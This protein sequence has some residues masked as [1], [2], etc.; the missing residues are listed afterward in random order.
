[1]KDKRLIR[2]RKYIRLGVRIKI[3]FQ[4]RK[5]KGGQPASDRIRAI[6]RD[7]SMDGISFVSGS[8]LQP[9]DLLKLEIF[10]PSHPKALHLEGKVIWTSPVK[11]MGR[12]MLETGVK[13]FNMSKADENSFVQYIMR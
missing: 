4:V 2:K 13:L 10:L 3:N 9:G 8:R 6:T 5:K 1:M 7:L 12:E 11:Q